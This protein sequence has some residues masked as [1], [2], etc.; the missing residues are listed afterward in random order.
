[1]AEK[2]ARAWD[3]VATVQGLLRDFAGAVPTHERALQI[4]VAI[5]D[6]D[7]EITVTN[8][9][10]MTLLDQGDYPRALAIA[11][12]SLELARHD[13]WPTVLENA[14]DTV[15][16]ILVAMGE[17]AQAQTLFEEALGDAPLA[18]QLYQAYLRKNLGRVYLVQG[19]TER[20]EVQIEAALGLAR[21]AHLSREQAEC[22]ELL[23][24]LAE[25]TGD[26]AGALAHFKQFHNLRESIVGEEAAKQ[27]ALTHVIHEVETAKRDAEIQRLRNLELQTEIEERKRFQ[28][29][30]EILVRSDSL[31]GLYNRGYFFG[32]AEQEF[33]RAVQFNR[34]LAV[35]MLDLDHFKRVNDT[36][37]HAIGDQVLMGVAGRLRAGL[38]KV[39]L[40]GRIG[41][42]E[43]AVVLP[44]TSPSEALETAQRLC[45]ALAVA[46]PTTAGLIVVTTSVG[47]CGLL[48]QPAPTGFTFDQLLGCADLAM[49][50]AKR[51]GRNQA[52][53]EYLPGTTT[54]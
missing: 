31:T 11:Q 25:T 48:P 1:L 9:Y 46:L 41:G 15:G 32:L 49:Y 53:I 36:H 33:G 7:A 14:L 6:R 2:E 45:R 8:N 39:D 43:F 34:P 24:T 16:Q 29:S 52:Q 37:G 3:A 27:L 51:A 40:L 44:E 18:S 23:A 12:R 38:R 28:A 10:A 21:Q 20:A 42:E 17:Y 50:R 54:E 13:S 35:L 19:A 22:H 47:V 26:L 30:L 5:Q 4:A